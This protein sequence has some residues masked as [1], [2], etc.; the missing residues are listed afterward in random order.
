MKTPFIT[1]ALAATILSG[2][3]SSGPAISKSTLGNLRLYVTAPEG[4][5]VHAAQ[6][7]VDGVFV[8]NVSRNWPVLYPK[9]GR[10]TITVELAGMKTYQHE[11]EILG[12]PY[13]GPDAC[14]QLLEVSLQRQ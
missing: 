4:V 1:L 9:R 5:D 14:T 12:D 6:I 10:R 7:Y 13:H 8:G 2:C 11:V 3:I